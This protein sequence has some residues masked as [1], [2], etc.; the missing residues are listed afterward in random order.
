MKN[1]DVISIIITFAIGVFAG[2]YLYLVGFAT[3]FN[4]PEA[5][6]EAIYTKLV[7][8]GE[9]Y[10]ECEEDNRCLS[11]QVLEDGTYRALFDNLDGGEKLVREGTVSS[12]LMRELKSTLITSTLQAE[13]KIL[14]TPN[15]YYGSDST[16]FRFKVTLDANEYPLDTCLS[17]INFE[18]K[19]WIV[20]S[21]LWSYVI[22]S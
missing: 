20:L 18:G 11:F 16:N 21:E 8:V 4:L 17:N 5:S 7:I 1:Q 13:S 10:G 2:G 12:S 14:N 22:N 6:T 15:C 19:A 9:S 3:T